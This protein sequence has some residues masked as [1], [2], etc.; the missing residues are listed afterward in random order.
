MFVVLL[1]R[2]IAILNG[3]KSPSVK[4][5]GNTPCILVIIVKSSYKIAI[6][7]P[8]SW[9]RYRRLEEIKQLL[10]AIQQRFKIAKAVGY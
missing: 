6:T 3:I 7:S 2:K 4:N 9:M 1:P 5:K 10:R 8:I